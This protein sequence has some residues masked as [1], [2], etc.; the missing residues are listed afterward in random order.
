M[1][2]S[3]N[4]YVMASIKFNNLSKPVNVDVASK[5]YRYVDINLD[6]QYEKTTGSDL[7]RQQDQNRDLKIS[8]DEFAIRNSLVNLFNTRRGQRILLPRYGVNLDGII[9]ERV[10]KEYGEIL[11]DTLLDAIQ[12]WE[13]RVTVRKIRVVAQAEL[14]QY[15]VTI[16][17]EIPSLKYKTT[18][19]F[20][21][22]TNEGFRESNNSEFI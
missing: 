16:S 2:V 1:P 17:V 15:S 8:P 5:N 12:T 4:I 14:N 3:V 10:T 7:K 21:V 13:K 9:F 11:G 19:I 22:L 6:L 20:G 18:S